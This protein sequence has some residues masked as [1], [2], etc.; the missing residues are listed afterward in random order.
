M[1]F[2]VD[3]RF[4]APLDA[5]LALYSDPDFFT[6]L[7][8]TERLAT[9][10]LVTVERTD[11]VVE[12]A[13]RH[14]LTAELPSMVTKFVDPAKLT[15]VETTTLHLGD[16]R[17]SSNLLPDEYPDLLKAS[18]AAVFSVDGDGTRRMVRGTVEVPVPIFGSKVE[19]AIVEGLEAHLDN[20]VVEARR[21]LAAR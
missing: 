16:A 2:T 17:S 9:P 19:G 8:P 10:I 20:E 14:R 18:A 4:D 5:V 3:Q 11:T 1:D 6:S 13:L 15:W 21:R 12:L 7:P